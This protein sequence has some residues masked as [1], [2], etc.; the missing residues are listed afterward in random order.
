M[1]KYCLVKVVQWAE[2]SGVMGRKRLQKVIFFLQEAGFPSEAEFTLHHF[3]PYSRDVAEACDELVSAGMLV[4]RAF[5]NLVGTQYSYSLAPGAAAS[6]LSQTERRLSIQAKRV[7]AYQQLANTLLA[8]DLWELELGSTIY[9]FQ[10]REQDWAKA[11]RQACAFKKVDPNSALAAEALAKSIYASLD[12][13][14]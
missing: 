2:P 11:I 4:E 10:K 6:A 8:R 13:A 9:Y 7:E 5:G 1:D 12:G 3:G 14:R